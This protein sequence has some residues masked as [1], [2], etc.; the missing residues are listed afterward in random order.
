[1][2][3]HDEPAAID[4]CLAAGAMGLVLKRSAATDLIPAIERALAGSAYVSPCMSSH[5]R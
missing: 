3:V 1:M 4:E 2:S 5:A